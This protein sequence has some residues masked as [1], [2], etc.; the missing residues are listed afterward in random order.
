MVSL[1]SGISNMN[2]TAP[3]LDLK[4]LRPAGWPGPRPDTFNYGQPVHASLDEAEK[5]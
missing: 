3:N 1:G 4:F 5:K 2:S